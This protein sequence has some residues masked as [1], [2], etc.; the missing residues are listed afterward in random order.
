MAIRFGHKKC[1]TA[2]EVEANSMVQL[3]NTR[4]RRRVWLST[5]S[6]IA[7]QKA[8]LKLPVQ[9]RMVHFIQAVAL[10]KRH[11]TLS[12]TV[13][14]SSASSHSRTKSAALRCADRILVATKLLTLALICVSKKQNQVAHNAETESTSNSR[15]QNSHPSSK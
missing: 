6:P 14:T 10:L 12:L 3:G 9:R 7:R 11:T 4:V 1:S 5:P 13:S 15:S 8:A 2:T